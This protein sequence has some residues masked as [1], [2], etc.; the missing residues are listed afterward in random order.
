MVLANTQ[1]L[2]QSNVALSDALKSIENHFGVIISYSD[3]KVSDLNVSLNMSD[4]S[5]EKTL[6]SLFSNLDLN[7]EVIDGSNV[8]IYLPTNPVA[9][10]IIVI[11][12]GYIFGEGDNIPVEF[13]DV[14]TKDLSKAVSTDVNG[15]FEIKTEQNQ[16]LISSYLGYEKLNIPFEEKNESLKCK[17]Y[18]LKKSSILLNPVEITEY[19]ADGISQTSGSNAI[20]IEPPKMHTLPGDLDGDILAAVQFLPG[21]NSPSESLD[22]IHVRGGTPDQNLIL[23]DGIPVYQVSHF[24]G[25]ISAFNP[26]LVDSVNVYRSGIGSKYGGRVSSVIDINMINDRP[27]RFT[28]GAGLNMTQGHLEI[29]TPLWKDA[30]LFLATRTS[31]SDGIETA[32]FD[33]FAEKVFQGTK[34]EDADF[35]AP[36]GDQ[37]QFNDGNFKFIYNPGSNK[38]TLST[39]GGLNSL[40]FESRFP[41][42][43]L[44]TKDTL[45]LNHAGALL[46]WEKAWSSRFNSKLSIY[47]SSFTN[48]YNLSLRN[49]NKQDSLIAFNSSLNTI[50]DGGIDLDFSYQTRENQKLSF[51]LQVTEKDVALELNRL[52]DSVSTKE[53]ISTKN[54]VQGLYGEYDLNLSNII[55]LNMGLR[56]QYDDLKKRDYFAP[57]LSAKT[58]LTDNL[59]IKLSTSK[60]FQFVSQLVLLNINDLGLS[61][62]IWV[63]TSD[64]NQIPVIESN[65]WTGG[66]EYNKEDWT[67]DIEGYVKELTGITTFSTLG[68]QGSVFDRGVSKIRGIDILIKKRFNNFRSWLS[69]TMSESL[70]EF[71]ALNDGPFAA[72]HDQTN[73]IQWVNLFKHGN[74]EYSAGIQLKSGLPFTKAIGIDSIML[75]DETYRYSIDYESINSSRLIPYLRLD[76]S[77]VYHFGKSRTKGFRGYAGFSIQNF[78]NRTNVLRRRYAIAE[79]DTRSPSLLTIDEYGLRFT[80]NLSINIWFP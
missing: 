57:R 12:C 45:A 75:E 26:F 35:N 41:G 4:N 69:W 54:S 9:K 78:T 18:Q 65:Q 43:R 10:P 22:G 70:Y 40:G 73:V 38:F 66:I 32:T 53:L 29:A 51:G 8:F 24:F 36:A 49:S 71:S 74:W 33:K 11:Q 30:A 47:G 58:S 37:L 21:I 80:P 6:Q 59:D 3:D 76:A 72:N 16:D 67:I 68:P 77:V 39:F 17:Q 31:I 48:D 19:L 25:T 20:I 1:S 13:A 63:A 27:K 42:A 56:Y 46:K 14:Y 61:N 15:Y 34:L 52:K 7:Y 62:D 23:W 60:H 5:L 2:A 64:E 79:Q 55:Q 44:F 28:V 50:E